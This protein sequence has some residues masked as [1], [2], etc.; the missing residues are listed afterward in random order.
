M[1]QSTTAINHEYGLMTR[2]ANASIDAF[3]K[4]IPRPAITPG[5]LESVRLIAHRGCH[6]SGVCRF[7]NTLDSFDTARNAGV[8]GIEFDIQWTRDSVPVVIHDPHT[9]R[10]PGTAAVEVAQIDFDELREYCPIVPRLEEV[11]ERY[12]GSVHLMIELK[13]ETWSR[14]VAKRLQTCLSS[15]EP[16]VDFHLMSLNV[17][18]LRLADY[19]QEEAKLLIATTNTRQMY[20]HTL[21]GGYGGLTG[22]Y[23]LLNREMRR[24][25]AARN[26]PWGTG[27]VN[28]VNLLAREIRSGTRWVFSDAADRLKAE[29][30]RLR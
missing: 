25:F 10:L 21:D 4:W 18:A 11:V 5:E 16:I 14:A 26:L 12:A 24:Q 28:S 23:F 19:L 2:I 27:F 8:W 22:H 1:T 6:D 17:D 15:I 29:L 9:G 7:E 20:K 13:T 30:N 3:Y